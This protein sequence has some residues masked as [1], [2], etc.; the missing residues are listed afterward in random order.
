MSEA[1]KPHGFQ[2]K[3]LA[4]KGV[5]VSH[6]IDEVY[7]N[8]VSKWQAVS[9]VKLE[10]WGRTLLLDDKIQSCEHDE[11][12]YHESL[13]HAPL[14]SHPNPKRVFIAGGG[15]GATAREVLRH[16]SVEQLVMVDIDPFA[17]E[18]SRKYLED[19]HKGAFDNPRMKLVIDD[20]K[21]YLLETEELFDVIV[22]DLAD[23]VEDGPC[24]LL[25]TEEFYTMLAGR[26]APGGVVVTQAGPA[27]AHTV[28]DVCL[29]IFNTLRRVFANAHLYRSHI[30]SFLD[31]YG[32]AI[33]SNEVDVARALL[34]PAAD[35]DALVEAR[36]DA[37]HEDGGKAGAACLRYYD[38]ETHGRMFAW[39]KQLRAAVAANSTIITD[40]APRYL[41]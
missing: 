30:P 8:G 3:E 21:K 32:F 4:V 38:A 10:Q 35:V 22:L 17:V 37:T 40:A 5:E 31:I 7:F 16:K 23:P 26:L 28:D 20:A 39:D 34:P 2:F 15:E 29:P 6:T 25:Y 41:Q 12:V 1:L 9:V 11:H 18:T 14:L 33:A 19:H 13:V 36:L 27:G 24:Y